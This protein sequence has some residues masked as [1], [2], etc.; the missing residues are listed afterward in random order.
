MHQVK[1]E[2]S[3]RFYFLRK[4]DLKFRF[5]FTLV[6]HC[7][8]IFLDIYKSVKVFLII[9]NVL[10]RSDAKSNNEEGEKEEQ[11][12]RYVSGVARRPHGHTPS[13][14]TSLLESSESSNQTM[15][16]SS[17][18]SSLNT[19]DQSISGVGFDIEVQPT[20]CENPGRETPTMFV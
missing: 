10:I 7:K 13:L 17:A 8:E 16:E 14:D 12:E 4:T 11:R 5:S 9:A 19:S 6:S 2:H 20:G 18:E 1:A 3:T 15:D